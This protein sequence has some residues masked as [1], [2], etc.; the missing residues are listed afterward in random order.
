[1]RCAHDSA[2]GPWQTQSTGLGIHLPLAEAGGVSLCSRGQAFFI[3]M[4]FQWKFFFLEMKVFLWN[5]C[6][7]KKIPINICQLLVLKYSL[8]FFSPPCLFQVVEEK[9]SGLVIWEVYFC[10]KT[11]SWGKK[12]HLAD[13]SN[14]GIEHFWAPFP[15]VII[16][17]W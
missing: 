3:R 13:S 9:N 8:F 7:P 17:S 4:I 10:R 14:S 5:N 2:R 6:L 12:T 1:M 15:Q 11:F 16:S